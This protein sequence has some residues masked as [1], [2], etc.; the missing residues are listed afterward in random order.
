MANIVET[1]VL[2]NLILPA[3]KSYAPNLLRHAASA[4]AGGL[5]TVGVIQGTQG[6]AVT[7]GILI[8]LS[9]LWSLAEKKGLLNKLFD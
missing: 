8:V 5:V 4:A 9:G 1:T 6:D 2:K 3:I 7:G